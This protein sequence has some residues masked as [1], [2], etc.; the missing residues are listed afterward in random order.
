MP[1]KAVSP[2][3]K[4]HG[5]GYLGID[6][7][8]PAGQATDIQVAVLELSGTEQRLPFRRNERL[9]NVISG[10]IA[11]LCGLQGT[12]LF[13]QQHLTVGILEKDPSLGGMILRSETG[14]RHRHVTA[15]PANPVFRLPNRLVINQF[16]QRNR[17]FGQDPD[18]D[19]ILRERLDIQGTFRHGNPNLLFPAGEEG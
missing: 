14:C 17:T 19:G 4:D 7:R 18:T 9:R 10:V 15:V 3:G 16:L 5:Q 12:A 11:D 6:L 8:Q 2:V 1:Q 13:F